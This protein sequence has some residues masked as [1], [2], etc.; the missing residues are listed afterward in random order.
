VA[1]IHNDSMLRRGLILSLPEQ[2]LYI[3]LECP[4]EF[5]LL[6]STLLSG[7][8]YR[9]VTLKE[10]DISVVNDRKSSVVSK[11][12]GLIGR[13]KDI[14]STFNVLLNAVAYEVTARLEYC[15]LVH[16]AAFKKDDERIIVVGNKKAGKSTYIVNQCLSAGECISDDLVV[17]DNA[18]RI[19]SLGFPV[20]LRRPINDDLVAALGKKSFVA[21]SSL[22]FVNPKSVNQLPAGKW[23]DVSKFQLLEREQ[24]HSIDTA[25]GYKELANRT[26][27]QP[28][29]R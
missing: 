13:H 10:Y 23:I 21:G 14:I 16:A 24:T 12:Y 4:A 8:S 29:T 11:K 3:S 18:C 20:R 17:W 9:T 2:G 15:L 27:P 28:T 5:H 6:V 22:A 1:L 19:M 26:I 25:A 7:W